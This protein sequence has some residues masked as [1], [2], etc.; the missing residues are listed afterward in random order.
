MLKDYPEHCK[1]IAG[2]IDRNYRFISA[3]VQSAVGMF[4]NSSVS[5]FVS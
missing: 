3:I 2:A 5:N 1:D 4:E